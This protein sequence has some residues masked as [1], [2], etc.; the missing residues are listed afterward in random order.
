MLKKFTNNIKG[1]SISL[2]T[3]GGIFLLAIIFVLFSNP[4][5]EKKEL[6]VNNEEIY[7]LFDNIKDNYSLIIEEEMND[8]TNKYSYDRDEN[9]ELVS[10][11][12]EDSGYMLYNNKYFKVQSDRKISKLKTS[13]PLFNN[14]YI[15]YDIIKDLVKK[16]DFKY[17][18]TNNTSCNISVNDYVSFLNDT[19]NTEYNLSSNENIY[20]NVTYSTRIYTIT[21]DYSNFDVLVNN[22]EKLIYKISINNIN[23]NDYSEIIDYFKKTLEK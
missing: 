11:E 8:K 1:S 23:K 17:I 6:T 21:I 19:L 5:Y 10:T 13:Y 2:L 4:K 16:C 20:I 12:N 18:D 9:V 3:C 7:K 14:F 22:N 15:K